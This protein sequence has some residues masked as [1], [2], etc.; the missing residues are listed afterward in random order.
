MNNRRRWR[1]L[2]LVVFAVVLGAGIVVEAKYHRAYRGP[3]NAAVFLAAIP[4]VWCW[5]PRGKGGASKT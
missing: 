2:S 4:M 5:R 1:W 3:V